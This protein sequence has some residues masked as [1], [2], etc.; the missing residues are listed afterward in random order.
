MGI[1]LE[2][3]SE[4]EALRP[5]RVAAVSGAVT[6]TTTRPPDDVD[7]RGDAGMPEESGATVR[8]GGGGGGEKDDGA[9]AEAEAECVTP[10]SAVSAV[11]QATACPPAPRKPRQAKRMKRCGCGWPP[12]FFMVPRDLADV[13]VARAPVAPSPP[14]PPA[15]KIRVHAVG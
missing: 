13:F 5:I 1:E 4:L 2:L 10:T 15:K 7:G 9:V 12:R 6:A 8:Q 3:S 11:P 14:C